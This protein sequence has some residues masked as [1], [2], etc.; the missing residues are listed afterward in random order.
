MLPPAAAAAFCLSHV[1]FYTTTTTQTP[2]TAN[3]N[4]HQ[5]QVLAGAS[6]GGAVAVDF[7]HA[8]PEA[9]EKLVSG[10]VRECVLGL[11]GGLIRRPAV[12]DLNLAD[13]TAPPP[14]NR[15]TTHTRTHETQILIDGQVYI[16][17][18][19]AMSSF[20]KPIA[21]LGIQVRV[22]VRILMIGRSPRIIIDHDGATNTI[23]RVGRKNSVEAYYI[24]DQHYTQ[25]LTYRQ[26]QIRCLSP[27]P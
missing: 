24:H 13:R 10:C 20:P 5:R 7:A 8:H 23:K 3:H 27:S 25:S 17:G 16:D 4:H 1:Q 19:G 21:S 14:S 22:R 6:L 18:V 15:P 26:K 2:T 11:L 9:V 12:E